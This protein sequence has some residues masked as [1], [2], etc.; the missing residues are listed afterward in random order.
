MIIGAKV[1]GQQFGVANSSELVWFGILGLAHGQGNGFIKYPLLI[2][3]VA[4]R[5]LANSKLFSIDLGKQ[6]SPGGE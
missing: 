6:S 2:D 3:S 5:G 4:A 1:E